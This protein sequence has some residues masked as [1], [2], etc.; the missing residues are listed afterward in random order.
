[1]FCLKVGRSVSRAESE[2]LRQLSER[3]KETNNKPAVYAVTL[4]LFYYFD[5]F[6]VSYGLYLDS[7]MWLFLHLLTA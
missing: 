4:T 5:T 2:A 6:M 7:I 1:M 3:G